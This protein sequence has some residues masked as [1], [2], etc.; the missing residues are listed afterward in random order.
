MNA[1]A[2]TIQRV[3]RGHLGRIKAKDVW[4]SKFNPGVLWRRKE[5]RPPQQPLDLL[6]ARARAFTKGIFNTNYI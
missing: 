1:N 6:M 5:R 3:F 2:L 4:L